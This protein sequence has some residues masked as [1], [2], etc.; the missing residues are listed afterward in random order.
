M[1]FTVALTSALL[2]TSLLVLAGERPA[3]A[4]TKVAIIDMVKA[5]NETNEG[6]R[7]NDTLKKYYDKRQGELN[8]RQ[9]DLLKEKNAIEKRCRSLPPAQCQSSME[10]LQKK[11]VELQGLMSQYQQDIQKRQSETTQ[12][13]LTKMLAIVGRLARQSGYDL[14]VDRAAT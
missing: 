14:V 9:E 3:Q 12:P 2:G 8:G 7:A 5:I 13:M 11:L 6:A 10:E 1:R 4:Q